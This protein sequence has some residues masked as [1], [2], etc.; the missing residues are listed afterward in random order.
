MIT[1][2]LKKPGIPILNNPV[3]IDAAIQ[4]IQISIASLSWLA[5]S[6]GRA[7]TIPQNQ[8]NQKIVEPM[9]YQ[10]S[11][12]YYAVLPNDAFDSYSFFRVAGPRNTEEYRANMNIGGTY[13][14]K[15]IVDLIVWV[16]YKR[17]DPLKDFIF[18]EQLIRDVMNKLNRDPNVEVVRVWDDQAD[19]IYKGYSL[20][21]THRDL[22]L[23]PHDAFRIEMN[24]R[25]QFTCGGEETTSGGLL[26][27]EGGF[28]EL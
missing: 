12:E 18:K 19:Q 20:K 8:G 28:L 9:V 7:W 15:D 25:Y 22:L 1:E 17:I 21:P 24:L 11:K 26:L 2:T 27:I 13:I 4:R 3:G 10:G 16:D 6:F 5:K 14:F 23:Y